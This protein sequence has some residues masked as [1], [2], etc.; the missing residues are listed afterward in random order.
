M[1]KLDDLRHQYTQGGLDERDCAPEPIAQ[2][3]RWFGEARAAGAAEPNAMTLA[4]AG[5]AGPNARTVLL[6]SADTLGFVFYTNYR[7]QKGRELAQD[8]RAALLFFWAEVER[9][10]RVL[11]RVERLPREESLAY[12]HT[13]PRGSQL[14]AWVSRQSRPIADR[15]ALEARLAEVE[16]EYEGREVPLPPYWGGYR[17][18][19]EVVEFWQGRPNRLHDRLVYRQ[20]RT[21]WTLQRLSP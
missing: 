9:Q 21:K 4:T 16:H 6:K 14:G 18:R 20:A 2:F 3:E 19:H 8:P 1:V 11:G 13:R 15:Q 12:F 10:V 7:S 5:A 17:L